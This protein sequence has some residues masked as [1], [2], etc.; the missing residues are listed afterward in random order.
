MKQQFLIQR[1][2][3]NV[4]SNQ[5]LL[6]SMYGT[7]GAYGDPTSFEDFE[8]LSRDK[9]IGFYK[10]NIQ[11]APQM[12]FA[13]GKIGKE[14]KNLIIHTFGNLKIN[15][16]LTTEPEIIGK[17]ALTDDL[18]EIPMKNTNQVSMR[19]GKITMPADQTGFWNL[20][21]L[22]TI[23]GG[24][25]GS[26]LN[27]ILREEKGLTYGVHAYIT[28]L[29]YSAYLNIHSELNRDNRDEAYEATLSVFNDLKSDPIKNEE[30]EMVVRYIKGNLLQSVDGA[31]AQS[32]YLLTSKTLG[33]DQNRAHRYFDFLNHVS[34]EEI[35]Q[36]AQNYLKEN[37][38]YKI[39]AGV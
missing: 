29:K 39:I 13:S 32:N 30:L 35:M 28:R 38:F 5:A 12:I 23:L 20:S 24:Y 4:I 22:T 9:L 1:E 2:Q 6:N 10:S 16:V 36:T 8:T 21:I 37:S 34:P 19:F 14:L 7:N 3:V 27:K 31:F 17:V 15:K 33:L 18:I 25:F 26:R 11:H